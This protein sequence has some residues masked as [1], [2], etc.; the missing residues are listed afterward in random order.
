MNVRNG[1]RVEIFDVSGES[2]LGW[3]Y[4]MAHWPEP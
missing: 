4:V 2:A 3:Y 1:Q